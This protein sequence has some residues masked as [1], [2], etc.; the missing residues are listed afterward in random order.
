MKLS[1]MLMPS[2]V[3]LENELRSPLT[4]VVPLVATTP[5]WVWKSEV[6]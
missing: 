4:E 3:T 1:W 5:G 2:S 6:T